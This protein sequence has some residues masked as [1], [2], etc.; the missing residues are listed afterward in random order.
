[1]PYMDGMGLSQTWIF[2]EEHAVKN[3]ERAAVGGGC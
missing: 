2:K 1:M 3:Q